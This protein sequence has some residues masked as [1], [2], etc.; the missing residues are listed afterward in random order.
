MC[1]AVWFLQLAAQVDDRIVLIGIVMGLPAEY[2][3]ASMAFKE[4]NANI[5]P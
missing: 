4:W 2:P 3:A 5:Q 1:T